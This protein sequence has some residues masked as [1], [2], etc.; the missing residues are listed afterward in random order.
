M[1]EILTALNPQGE[2][3]QIVRAPLS[4]RQADYAGRTIYLISSWPKNAGFD[5]VVEEWK[6]HMSHKHA[7]VVFVE[8][9]RNQYSSDQPELWE[10]V[11]EKADAFVYLAAPS[12][13]TTAYAITWPARYLERNGTPGV[14]L[15]Y[16]YL[17]ETAVVSC[18]R[19]GMQIRYVKLP[20]PCTELSPEQKKQFFEELD[21]A[22]STPP[23]GDEL[24]AGAYTPAQPERI[25]IQ[26]TEREI[27]D[28]FY[29]NGYTDGLPIEIPTPERVEA[30]LGGT[31]HKHDEVVCSKMAPEGRAVT[32]EKVA[33]NAV[34]AG[35]EPC[36]MPVLLAAC[37]IMG[38]NERYHA[39]SKSTN[40]F[41]F[42]QVVNGPI[43]DEIGMNS[44]VYALGPGNRPNAAIGR[45]LRLALTNL[46]GAEVGV[47]LMGVQGNT[48]SYTFAFAEN[49]EH[50]PWAPLAQ[51][52][53]YAPGESVLSIFGGCSSHCGNYMFNKDE[54]NMMRGIK[55]FESLGGCAVLLSPFRAKRICDRGFDTRE[56]MEEYLWRQ[57]S[58]PLS[59][60][61]SLGLFERYIVRNLK[62][63]TGDFPE[64][65]ATLPDDTV[66]PIFPRRK[67]NV[68][69]VGDPEGTDV[70]Q[71]WMTHGGETASIDK[72]R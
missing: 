43:R 67:F 36:Y 40:S 31:S 62:N 29:Q 24:T 6:Q 7:G 12:C 35:A 68:M 64:E 37:E 42:M 30:M 21:G 46:G 9:T 59:E 33:I 48:A 22:L 53:G 51:D 72:W 23:K 56:K 63:K 3:G 4:A 28:F 1:S 47:N 50:S 55:A 39:S 65:Y 15:I 25:A 17:E 71:A 45:F 70:M 49:E 27:K 44:G 10:E 8:K 54:S 19:E 26:G 18:E 69:V 20:Y 2:F 16:D 14:V 41:A 66:V 34:M 38:R 11:R 13:S 61:K 58:M 32:V 5:T 57:A 52:F 60:L